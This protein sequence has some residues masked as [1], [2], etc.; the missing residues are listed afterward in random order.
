VAAVVLFKTKQEKTKQNRSENISSWKIYFTS[1]GQIRILR[2]YVIALGV[3]SFG[4]IFVSARTNKR[5]HHH[6]C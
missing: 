6:R 1:K 4:L 5:H 2:V 3:Y